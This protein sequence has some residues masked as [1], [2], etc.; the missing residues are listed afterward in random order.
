M[1]KLKITLACVGGVS[2]SI[3]AKKIAKA[4]NAKGFL[5]TECNAYAISSLGKV[6]PGSDVI[7]LGPQVLYLLDSVK[8]EFPDI[9]VE[10][11]E[12]RDYGMMN[13]EKVFTDLLKKFKWTNIEWFGGDYEKNWIGTNK[14]Y[15]S[16]R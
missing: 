6:A 5:E 16:S 1:R 7:L 14:I 3:L 4:A 11:V 15:E 13:G 2:T 10:L 9:P 12:Q 8:K